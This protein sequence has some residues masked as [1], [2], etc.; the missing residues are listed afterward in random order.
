MSYK[1]IPKHIAIIMDGNGRWAAQRHLPRYQGHLKGV[2]RVEE[3]IRKAVE[4][5]IGVLT[6]YAF[7]TE[8]WQRPAREVSSLMNLL[9]TVLDQKTR[10]MSKQNIR[11][12]FIGL[13]AGIPPKVLKQIDESVE[14]TRNN[15]GMVLNIAFNYGARDEI[16]QAARTLAQKVHRGQLNPEDIDEDLFGRMLYTNGL[17]DPDLLIRT[18]GEKRI[19][20][21]LLWQIS[22][23]EFYFT[24]THWPDFGADKFLEAIEFYRRRERRYGRIAV[25]HR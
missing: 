8:N 15:T 19:S 22:Y 5:G 21:F 3:I 1:R 11:L 20:N 16:V 4:L 24:E 7:S 17:P 10:L 13:R 14:K 23:S 25:Q 6:F 9:C 18:S 2:K 12:R